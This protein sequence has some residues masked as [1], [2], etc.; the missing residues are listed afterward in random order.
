MSAARKLLE[1]VEGLGGRVYLDSGKVKLAARAPLP[2]R[3]V[4][5]LRQ[6]REEIE[7]ELRRAEVE[8]RLNAMARE[9]ERRRDWWV[10]PVEG[11][12]QGVVTF[13]SAVT[14]EEVVVSLWGR[15]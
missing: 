8:R 6:H 9:N 3:I 2:E 13:R 14:G 10:K 11:R 12:R 1:Q 7:A 15:G 4:I 5:D